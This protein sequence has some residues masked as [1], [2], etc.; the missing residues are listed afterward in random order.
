MKK[1]ITLLALSFI[2]VSMNAQSEV[3][4]NNGKKVILNDDG[5]WVYASIETEESIDISDDCST[6]ISTKTD[7]VTGKST[8]SLSETLIISK[9]GGEKG[10]GVIAMK[11]DKKSLI[12]SI[13]AIGAGNCID[14]KGKMNVLFRDGTR[15]EL[16]NDGDFNCNANYVQYFGGVFGKKK[17][18]E[19]FKNKEIETIRVW[20]SKGYVEENLT[21]EQSK[22]FMNSM[23]CLSNS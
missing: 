7:K 15:L 18:I 17:E 3:I 12:L 4:T 6:Y 23:R 20:T 2:S 16:T 22:I 13:K 19:M 1:I 8:T 9:D 5:T 11:A 10:F 14:D 21:D